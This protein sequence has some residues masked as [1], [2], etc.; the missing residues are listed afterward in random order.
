MRKWVLL[1]LLAVLL[2]FIFTRRE[3]FQDTDGIKGIYTLD[4]SGSDRFIGSSVENVIRLMPATLIKALQ[5]AKPK[6]PCPTVAK[7]SK[8][9]PADPTTGA[10]AM[11][12]VRGDINDIMVAF[13]SRVY[14]RSNATVG[15]STTDVTQFLSTYPMTPFLTANKEDVKALLVAYFVSQ[16]AGVANTGTNDPRLVNAAAPDPATT[17]PELVARWNRENGWSD[18]AAGVRSAGAAEARGY[19][20]YDVQTTNQGSLP[21]PIDARDDPDDAEA[22][23]PSVGP[24]FGDNGPFSGTP[25]TG[26]GSGMNAAAALTGSTYAHPPATEGRLDPYDF[27][28]GSSTPPPLGG[29]KLPV[30]G[31]KSGGVGARPITSTQSSSQPAPALYGPD[32]AATTQYSNSE[33]TY[34]MP[35]YRTTGSDPSNRYVGTSRVPGDQDLFPTLYAQSSSYSIANGSQKTDPVP[36]LSDFSVFQT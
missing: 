2:W 34:M 15:I 23:R 32:P 21:S 13:Y 22:A 19:N 9:C 8:Q 20:P 4:G 29:K 36:F 35:D 30:E 28:P 5:D 18:R 10:G 26:Q 6:T 14:Q 12:L 7:P 24:V 11:V 17:S 3:R 27:W 31:P 16:P 33:N 1:G 25:G